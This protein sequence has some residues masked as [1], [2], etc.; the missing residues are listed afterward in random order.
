MAQQLK[1]NVKVE[2]VVEKKNTKKMYLYIYT[3][4]EER[5]RTS[6][7]M[8]I[9]STTRRACAIIATIALGVTKH[10]GYAIIVSSMHVCD[11]SIYFK[12]QRW[13][14]PELLHK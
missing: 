5:S 14:V 8:P 13:F 3:S 1:S 7:V 9:R 4:I 10:P 11:I 6:A 2:E 12:I